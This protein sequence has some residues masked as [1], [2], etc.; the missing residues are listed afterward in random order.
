VRRLSL[1][2]R[3]GA[4]ALAL[5]AAGLLTLDLTGGSLQNA[6]SGARGV[7]GSLYR[8]SDSVLGPVRRFIQGVPDAGRSSAR[9]AALQREN[10]ALRSQLATNSVDAAT[11]AELARLRLA[12]GTAGL[13]V[14]PAH[15]IATG[16]GQGFDWTATIDVG[17]S[18]GIHLDQTVTSADGLVGRILRADASTSV[19]LLAADPS[20]GV[21]VRDTRT[22]QLGVAS[23]NGLRGFTLSPLDPD[24][25][26]RVGDVLE[27]GPVGAS[28]YAAG[29]LVGTVSAVHRNGATVTATMRAAI[30][31]TAIDV[32]GVIRSTGQT[33]ARGTD[34]VSVAGR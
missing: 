27:T 12:A 21:G 32:V 30:S 4:C 2:Q 10:A 23:G 31:P 17:T 22:N 18:S 20:S 19:V 24:T 14:V 25:D 11:S 29:L 16:A 5:I 34:P 9:I 28:T 33:T 3:L 7:M 26:V 13:D 15:I 1:R 6:H 8:G